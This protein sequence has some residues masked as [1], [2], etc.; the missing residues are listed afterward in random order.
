ME[1][2]KAAAQVLPCKHQ[3]LGCPKVSLGEG[4]GGNKPP[5]PRAGWGSR[6]GGLASS[7][8]RDTGIGLRRSRLC[9]GE[10]V[11]GGSQRLS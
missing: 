3:E 9:C 8:C 2:M 1:G 5:I 11:W 10:Q 6:I 7:H 4:T